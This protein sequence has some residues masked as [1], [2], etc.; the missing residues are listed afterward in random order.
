MSMA[1]GNR[2]SVVTASVYADEYQGSSIDM[3]DPNA[4]TLQFTKGDEVRV[5]GAMAMS[6]SIT[7]V[8]MD[9]YVQASWLQ[10]HDAGD[11]PG[12]ATIQIPSY[13]I[14]INDLIEGDYLVQA[15]SS[16][17][18]QIFEYTLKPTTPDS[19]SPTDTT[20]TIVRWTESRAQL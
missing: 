17:I 16:G 1:V 10:T 19:S 18:S 2:D 9:L 13:R 15:P 5:V 3:T 14:Q 6:S 8:K 7:F 4:V 12:W 11:P 20:W